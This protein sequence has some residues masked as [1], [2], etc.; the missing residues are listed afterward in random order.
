MS[1]RRSTSS[2]AQAGQATVE[3][4]ALLPLMAVLAA[5]GWQVVVAGQA[6]WLAGT[7]ARAAARAHALGND[8]GAGAR[9]ALPVQWRDDVRVKTKANGRVAVR[10]T[11]PVIVPGGDGGLGTV[12]REARFAPQDGR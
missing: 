7:A 5:F 1:P 4:V 8:A 10:L 6:V 11:V 2:S 12:A 3:L 9:A